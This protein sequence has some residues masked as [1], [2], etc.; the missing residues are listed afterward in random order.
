MKKVV[1]ISDDRRYVYIE[2]IRLSRSS[3]ILSITLQKN[4]GIYKD[5][6]WN[7]YVDVNLNDFSKFLGEYADLAY[8]VHLVRDMEDVKDYLF[9]LYK[10]CLVIDIPGVDD[11]MDMMKIA[12]EEWKKN[13]ILVIEK[14]TNKD[15][16]TNEKQEA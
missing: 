2:Y 3:S 13:P 8:S 1:T 15:G 16:G 10:Y 6:K 12:D 9:N 11:I 5:K 4:V 7:I 14:R